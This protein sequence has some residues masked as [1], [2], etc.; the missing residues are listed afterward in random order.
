MRVTID[1]MAHGGAA[2]GRVEGRVVFVR[3]AIPGEVVQV[4]VTG[5]GRRGR[6]LTADTVAVITASPDR[7]AP[8]CPIAGDCGGCDWQ[9]ISLTRQRTLKAEVVADQMARLGGVHREVTVTGGDATG[10]GWRTRM[11][12]AAADPGWGLR[13]HGS[14]DV[15]PVPECAVAVPGLNELLRSPPESRPGQQLVVIDQPGGAAWQRIPGDPPVTVTEQVGDRTWH[16]PAAA[17]WQAHRGAPRALLDAVAPHVHPVGVWWDLY[18]GVGLFAGALARPGQ[19][20][21]AVEGDR[22]AARAARRNL[23]DL[24]SVRVVARDVRQ[25]VA[26]APEPSPDAVVLD[27]PRTGAG[28]AVCTAL[29]QTS[30]TTLVY[31]A[32][33]PAALARD[34]RTLTDDGWRLDTLTGHDLFP[35]THHVEC[36]AVFH[37]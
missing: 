31:V 32:C 11:R 7:V 36:V 28:A 9:F 19:T 16:L 15:V 27:P 6:Y 24:A 21:T 14:H 26:A 3:G 10:L 37:R 22:A 12:F 5:E 30:A 13:R 35:M 23:A 34:T 2:V 17:F 8:P 1:R 25:W 20:V 4:R 29:G 33:D 18:S